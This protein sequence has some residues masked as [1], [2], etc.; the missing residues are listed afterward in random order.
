MFAP[1]SP[2][3]DATSDDS[4]E[5]AERLARLAEGLRV[6]DFQHWGLAPVS[7]ELLYF[8]L[9]C[10]AMWG[11]ERDEIPWLLQIYVDALV[12]DTSACGSTVTVEALAEE[13]LAIVVECYA[14]FLADDCFDCRRPLEFESVSPGLQ[15]LVVRAASSTGDGLANG[16]MSTCGIDT[17]EATASV[18]TVRAKWSFSTDASA[19]SCSEA[20]TRAAQLDLLLDLGKIERDL[21]Y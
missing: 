14:S 8:I 11:I 10:L 20:L 13:M 6:I 7:F 18:G 9:H 2:W 12:S 1:L 16:C 19:Y 4:M 17:G 21:L 3:S 15:T 5:N